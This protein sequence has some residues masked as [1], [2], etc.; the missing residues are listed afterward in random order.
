MR[1]LKEANTNPIPLKPFVN[2]V[3]STLTCLL[4]PQHKALK[5]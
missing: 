2:L 4:L 1:L 3:V 5:I